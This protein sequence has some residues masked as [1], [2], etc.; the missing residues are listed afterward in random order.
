MKFQLNVFFTSLLY[1]YK[2]LFFARTERQNLHSLIYYKKE[3][4][5]TKAM[6]ENDEDFN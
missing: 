5:Q 3:K 2:L 1:Y 6:A 4:N